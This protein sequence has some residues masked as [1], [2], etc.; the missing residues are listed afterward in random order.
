MLTILSKLGIEI[1]CFV[2]KHEFCFVSKIDDVSSS[3][4][5]SRTSRATQSCFP[6]SGPTNHLE[7][8]RPPGFFCFFFLFFGSQS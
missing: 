8:T 7:V 5:V 1:S 2:L 4:K 6:V 3:I